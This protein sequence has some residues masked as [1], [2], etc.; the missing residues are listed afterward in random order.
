MNNHRTGNCL[1]VIILI[2]SGIGGY[3][4]WQTVLEERARK[5]KLKA[6]CIETMK[7]ITAAVEVCNKDKILGKFMAKD[8]ELKFLVE[9]K[10]LP[11][12]PTCPEAGTYKIYG[13]F[14]QSDGRIIC[15]VHTPVP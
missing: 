9:K 7:K 6:D 10:F 15:T 3:F 12:I 2:A 13:F 4:Y 8:L 11:S 14:G 5:A 1:I